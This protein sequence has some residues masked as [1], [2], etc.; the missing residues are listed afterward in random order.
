[1]AENTFEKTM[2]DLEEIVVKLEKG[3][4][5]LNDM[6]TLYEKGVLLSRV[7]NDMLNAAEEK[8]NL[9]IKK[10]DMHGLEKFVE[11]GI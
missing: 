8:I 10:G 11:E 6:L 2:A 1:M 4:L 3:D 9:L 7:C 5:P